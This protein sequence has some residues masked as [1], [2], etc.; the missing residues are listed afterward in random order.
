MNL[1]IKY[2]VSAAL[3]VGISE[4]GKRSSWLGAALAAIPLTSLLAFI[5]LHT[6]GVASSQIAEMSMQIVWLVLAS[7]PLF[8]IFAVMLNRGFGFWFS[9]G[10]SVVIT[11]LTYVGVAWWLKTN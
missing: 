9:L 5:W 3:I 2:A 8:I 10:F 1:W 6:E 4:L 7:L 11:S